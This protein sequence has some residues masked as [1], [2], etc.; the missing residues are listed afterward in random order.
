MTFQVN[1]VQGNLHWIPIALSTLTP[2]TSPHSS[3]I[4]LGFDYPVDRLLTHGTPETAELEELCR[5]LEWIA[6]ELTRIQGEYGGAVKFIVFQ[7]PDFR[8]L[9]AAP[10]N[11]R[12]RSCRVDVFCSTFF[13]YPFLVGPRALELL[14][15]I[16]AHFQALPSFPLK[17]SVVWPCVSPST[18][19][20]SG[21]RH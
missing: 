12:F 17:C 16:C 10:F 20:T 7:G 1:W 21:P 18:I 8:R 2:A 19:R 15:G 6:D 11:V 14:S 4:Y 5:N 9:A 13:I 3:S